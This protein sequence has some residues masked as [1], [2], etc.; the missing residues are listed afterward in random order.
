MIYLFHPLLHYLTVAMTNKV[1]IS[2]VHICDLN[3]HKAV[4]DNISTKFINA[5]QGSMVVYFLLAY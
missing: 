3:I 2:E 1:D 4:R 5:L